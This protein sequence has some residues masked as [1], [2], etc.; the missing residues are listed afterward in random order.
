MKENTLIE[1]KNKLDAMTRVMQQVINE[2]AH[3]RE[4]GVGTLETVK[5]LPG[6]EDAISTLKAK[7]EEEVELKKEAKKNGA[8]KQDTK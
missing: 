2:M 4:L 8:I 1:M 3:L 5:L 6:Y 7:M